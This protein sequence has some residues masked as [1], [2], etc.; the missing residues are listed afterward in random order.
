MIS[1]CVFIYGIISSLLSL[2]VTLVVTSKK[3]VESSFQKYQNL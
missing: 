3:L 1:N 2:S